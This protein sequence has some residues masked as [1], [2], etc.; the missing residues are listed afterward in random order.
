MTESLSIAIHA[1]TSRVS[2]CVSVDETLLPTNICA[3]IKL[4]ESYILK[5]DLTFD[6]QQ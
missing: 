1:F 3:L 6:N 2:M 5:Q 4:A